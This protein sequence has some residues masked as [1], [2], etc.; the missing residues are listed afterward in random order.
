VPTLVDR[1]GGS[2]ALRT[3]LSSAVARAAADPE[4]SEAAVALVASS[5]PEAQLEFVAGVL[6]GPEP[7]A[8]EP[9]LAAADA[10]RLAIHLGDALSLIGVSPALAAVA[11]S[12]LT[13]ALADSPGGRDRNL[14]LRGP[15]RGADQDRR[16]AAPPAQRAPG[17]SGGSRQ[18]APRE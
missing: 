4:L 8:L 6:D 12:R 14:A 16:D 1:L 9:A 18:D 7:V 2:D 17:R 10:R 5:T 15:S 13:A 11:G 3:A